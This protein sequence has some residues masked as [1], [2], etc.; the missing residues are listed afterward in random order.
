MEERAPA[1]P[2]LG[3]QPAPL[4]RR[5]R[6]RHDDVEG[7][8]ARLQNSEELAEN[9]LVALHDHSGRDRAV[10]VR[11]GQVAQGRGRHIE[12]QLR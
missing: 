8:I 10:D 7:R 1:A 4:L 3:Q 11:G 9:R 5:G 6:L 2:L 12:R